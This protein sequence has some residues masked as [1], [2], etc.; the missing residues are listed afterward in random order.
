MQRDE[1]LHVRLPSEVKDDAKLYAVYDSRT[2]SGF[3]VEAIK[4]R[5]NKLKLKQKKVD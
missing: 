2:L 1:Q 3:V 5:V 4:D